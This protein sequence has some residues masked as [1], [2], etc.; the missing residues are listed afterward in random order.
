MEF[1]FLIN[2]F[3]SHNEASILLTEKY[4]P[5]N[6]L[7]FYI[8][9]EHLVHLEKLK[10]Y[11][12]E[13]FSEINFEYKKLD[14]KNPSE[15]EK[16]ITTYGGKNGLCNITGGKKLVSLIVYTYCVKHNIKCTYVDIKNEILIDIGI[17]EIS[18]NKNSFVDLEIED[19]IKSM[20]ASIVID[21]TNLYSN[22]VLLAFTMWISQNMKV[23]DDL[24]ILLQDVNVFI[25]NEENPNILKLNNS[26]VNN[27][28]KRVLTERLNFLEKNGQIKIIIGKEFSE[29]EFLNDFIKTFLFKSGT[30]LEILTQ[31][32][33]EE[34]EVIDDVKSGLLFLWDNDKSNVRNEL[35]VVAI[36]DSTMICISCKDSKKYDEISLNEL[37]VYS[38]QIAGE[39]VIK[40]LVAAKEP[41]KTTI[42][43]RAKEMDINLVVFD[44]DIAKF[45]QV[46]SN[47][48][49]QKREAE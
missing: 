22:K 36:K 46:L 9:D 13:K 39:N 38:N 16:I 30:W 11:Y 41:S 18:H 20:G 3:D 34:I 43:Q 31:K 37:N 21:S 14:I 19:V 35:D 4:K 8:K 24:K 7:F 45:K 33:I 26:L 29:I 6:I 40:I 49:T 15:I 27:E 2:I 12:N 25:R 32:V 5:K 1:D 28:Q 48:I 44:G 23:W 10:N 47:V 42:L 17:D